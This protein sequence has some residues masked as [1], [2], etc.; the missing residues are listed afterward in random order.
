MKT[1]TV[2]S[3]VDSANVDY[4]RALYGITDL[5]LETVATVGSKL[6]PELDRLVDDFYEWLPQ[7]KEYDLFFPDAQSTDRIKALQKRYWED[8]FSG[9]VDEAYLESRKRVGAVHASI[10][11]SLQAYFAAMNTM[12]TLI[13]DH[14]GQVGFTDSN[15]IASITKLVHLDT[16]V[17]VDSFS[18]LTNQTISHQSEAIMAMS[19]PVTAIWD[20]ILLLPV[21]GIIDSRRAHD[22]MDAMLTRIKETE[23]TVFILDIS[24]VAAMDTAVANHLIKMTKAARL[25]GCTCIISGV[26]P[27]IASTIVE[28]GIDVGTVSTRANLKDALSLAFSKTDLQLVGSRARPESD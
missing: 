5:D 25:M 16:S 24:G 15:H 27:A 1:E 22:I 3:S 21:V 11:L 14:M 13:H 8:F 18:V 2:Q 10:G 28:L 17:V 19:T 9:N 6:L 12:L 20:N 23:A 7:L 26:S 4:Y